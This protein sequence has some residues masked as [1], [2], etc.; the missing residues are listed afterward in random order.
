M[1]D[2]DRHAVAEC[3]VM[4]RNTAHLTLHSASLGRRVTLAEPHGFLHTNGSLIETIRL[5]FVKAVWLVARGLVEPLSGR[6]GRQDGNDDERQGPQ[7]RD[8]DDQHQP[9]ADVDIVQ[10]ADQES[11]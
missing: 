3:L 2:Q 10:A 8:Q 4:Q 1:Q 7:E 9:A 11:Q 5:P 6:V